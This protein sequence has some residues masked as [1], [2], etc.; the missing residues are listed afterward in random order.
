MHLNSQWIRIVVVG[1]LAN[2][3]VV[4]FGV[5]QTILKRSTKAFS[6]NAIIAVRRRLRHRTNEM[7]FWNIWEAAKL[8]ASKFNKVEPLVVF[9]FSLEM[10]SPA[11]SGRQ[12]I[13]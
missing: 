4:N 12:Q 11:T 7:I 1:F 8:A 2:N 13:A 10:T 3:N 6:L 9:T 5:F